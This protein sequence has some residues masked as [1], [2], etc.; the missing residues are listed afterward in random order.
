LYTRAMLDIVLPRLADDE[1]GLLMVEARVDVLT[2]LRR[3]PLP[4]SAALVLHTTGGMSYRELEVFFYG[5][6]QPDRAGEFLVE[7][8]YLLLLGELNGEVD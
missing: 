7:V 2:A 5:K 4:Y 1:G 8:A 3:V 6:R